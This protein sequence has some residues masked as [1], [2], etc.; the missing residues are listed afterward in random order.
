MLYLNRRRYCFTESARLGPGS[1]GGGP[2]PCR[3]PR[4]R[5][6]KA[7]GRSPTTPDSRSG[8]RPHLPGPHNDGD[9]TITEVAAIWAYTTP[10]SAA[11]WCL[12]LR[13][14]RRPGPDDHHQG[15]TYPAFRHDFPSPNRRC[16]WALI[17]TRDRPH[18]APD[19]IGPSSS[20]ALRTRP[21]PST[22]ATFTVAPASHQF[23]TVSPLRTR[24]PR[25][26]RRDTRGVAG[27]V[28]PLLHDLPA[29]RTTTITP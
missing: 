23:G 27:G 19:G 4:R 22:S 5:H 28:L 9:L 24:L 12:R 2:G 10:A 26:R 7:I 25:P 16:L 29:D 13:Q 17:A 15:R 21:P 6:H 14:R 3:P 1:R 18:L 20:C 11:A 8:L